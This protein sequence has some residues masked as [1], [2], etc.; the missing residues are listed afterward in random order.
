MRYQLVDAMVGM[1]RQAIE[2][3]LEV[4]PGV[5]AV[6]LGRVGEAHDDRSALA[7]EFAAREEPCL[8]AHG[9][10]QVIPPMSGEKLKSSIAG[11][12]CTAVESDSAEYPDHPGRV[13]IGERSESGG[14]VTCAT[15]LHLSF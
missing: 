13:L 11:T 14:I 15:G 2:D 9:N 10:R 3:I 7:R 8:S 5:V 12:L 4:D 1:E 6:Q